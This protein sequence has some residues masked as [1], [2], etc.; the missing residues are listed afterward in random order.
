MRWLILK[1]TIKLRGREAMDR[2]RI[3]AMCARLLLGVLLATKA[4][5]ETGPLAESGAARKAEMPAIPVT[6]SV[7]ESRD[8]EE[9][10]TSVGQLE[11]KVAPLIAA[12]V[13]GRLT[14]VNVDV[15]NRI[16]QGQLL[17]EIDAE[18]FRLAR[19]M[20]QTDIDRLT[21]LIH[22]QQLKVERYRTLVEKKSANQ[23]T[24]D[25]I[26]AQLGALRAEL[27]SAQVRLQQAQRD[28][29][30]TR[31]TS[32][33]DGRVD[34]TQVSEGDYVKVGSPLMR[35]GNLH[36]LKARLP[37]PETLLTNL[38]AGLPVRLTS[39][40]APDVTVE[41][42]VSEVR[43]SITVGSRSA[44]VIVNVENPGPWEPGATV[45]A[46]LRVGLHE[47]AVLLPEISVVLRPAGTVV[48]VIDGDKAEQR[49]VTTGSRRDGQ[50]EIL[51]GLK[52]GERA[53]ADGAGFLTD[54]ALITV[55][56]P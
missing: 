48:Y 28:I 37:Y 5:A 54:G 8:L 44:Q 36:W 16:E 18:D 15:G 46:A 26:E 49:V 20:A 10:E 31:I 7:A 47:D 11:T 30:K 52:A 56:A 32:P 25:D 6:V 9:W 29:S 45:T 27:R 53:V 24:L 23:S 21:A 12:E 55:K 35:I 13:S 1:R 41:T 38:N 39:P 14:A 33:I 51:S 2:L 4:S 43:P 22:A 3:K 42:T 50:V 40:S 19:D 34:E 17:A